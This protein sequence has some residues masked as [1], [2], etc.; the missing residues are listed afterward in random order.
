MS[1]GDE[2]GSG[3]FA[4]VMKWVG[5]TTAILSLAGVIVGIVK[6]VA[7]RA[8]TRSQIENMLS[9][10]TVAA[11]GKDYEAAWQTL[12][13]AAKLDADSEKVRTAREDLAMAWLDDGV[14]AEPDGRYSGITAKLKPVLAQGVTST[15]PGP[16]Q[17]DLLAHI[18]WCYFLE[19][20]DGNS[21]L[22]LT[23][24]YAKAIEEDANNPYA[25]AM[26]GH[27]L[28]WEQVNLDEAE[29]HFSAGLASKREVD[30]VR[31]MQLEALMNHH[32]EQFDVEVV[33]VAN[34]MRKEQR[35]IDLRLT[36]PI[37]DIYPFEMNPREQVSTTFVNA[38]PPAEHLA[39]FHWL[40]DKTDSREDQKRERTYFLAVLSE[41]AGQRDEAL[42][43]YRS[44]QA[45]PSERAKGAITWAGVDAGI[46]RLSKA[47][48]AKS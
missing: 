27:W 21:G 36:R 28:L 44:L 9:S 39:T 25:Q 2:G 43:L 34:D 10:A 24:Q 30:Y 48:A 19:S 12:D 47:S 42:E 17:A 16:R 46:K 41:A 5:Y 23:G 26:W 4:A 45:T 22:D 15:K 13:D 32:G 40:F 7:H 18:G 1:P 3:K 8:E 33:R 31:R 29:K 14:H 6:V 11:Q 37:F 38:V 35:A 20:V